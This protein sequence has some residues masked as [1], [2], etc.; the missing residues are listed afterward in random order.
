MLV[1]LVDAAQVEIAELALSELVTNAVR[2]GSPRAGDI[3]EVEITVGSDQLR[4]VV[5]DRGPA[6]SFPDAPRAPDQS[7]GFGLHIAR[8]VADLTIDRTE[9]GN[10]VSF[11]VPIGGP[12]AAER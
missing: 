9:K 8:S 2:H 11:M 4:A 7:G 5:R 1:R 3:V 6:F 10:V 12:V